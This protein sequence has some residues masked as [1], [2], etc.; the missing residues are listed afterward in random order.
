MTSSIISW[1]LHDEGRALAV[2]AVV[3]IVLLLLCGWGAP[4]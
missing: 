2:L 3:V 1:W 4:K